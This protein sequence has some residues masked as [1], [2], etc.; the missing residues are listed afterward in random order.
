MVM[1]RRGYKGNVVVEEVE[2]VIVIVVVEVE[3]VVLIGGGRG[4]VVIGGGW[5]VDVE[6][7]TRV[8]TDGLRGRDDLGS[9][10]F[11]SSWASMKMSICSLRT[12]FA[13]ASNAFKKHAALKK[14]NE[15]EES[16]A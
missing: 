7:T 1:S 14:A 3:E 10:P 5:V 12:V 16:N 8:E 15:S 2:E 13:F 9:R 11:R 6:G 4:V